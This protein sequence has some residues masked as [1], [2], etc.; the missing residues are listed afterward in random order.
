MYGLRLVLIALCAAFAAAQ[1]DV[2]F[3]TRVPNPITDGANQVI[4][5][6]T[7]DTESDVTLRLLQGTSSPYRTIYTITT[8]GHGGEVRAIAKLVRE[9]P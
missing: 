6:S 7:N 5:W 3:F 9:L 1:S 2:L 8:T 4:L